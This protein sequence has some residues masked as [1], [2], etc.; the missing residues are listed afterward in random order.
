MAKIETYKNRKICV[1][2]VDGFEIGQD[3]EWEVVVEANKRLKFTETKTIVHG[4]LESQALKYGKDII[5]T[6]DKNHVL[7]Q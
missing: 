4:G 2:Q 5:D 6:F 7:A 3:N 1:Y